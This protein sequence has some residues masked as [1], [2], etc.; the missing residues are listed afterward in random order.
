MT[1]SYYFPV[2]EIYKKVNF[3]ML[4]IDKWVFSFHWKRMDHCINVCLEKESSGLR[5]SPESSYKSLFLAFIDLST[6]RQVEIHITNHVA[7]QHIF[8]SCTILL[9][10]SSKLLTSETRE[11]SIDTGINFD[12]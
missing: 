9:N 3:T 1:C 12:V 6:K 5:N 4:G 10:Q 7:H 11:L 8:Y 2:S